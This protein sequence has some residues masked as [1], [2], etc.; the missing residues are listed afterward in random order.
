MADLLA[1]QSTMIGF[2]FIPTLVGSFY[3][4]NYY[5][6]KNKL[7]KHDWPAF[8]GALFFNWTFFAITY[9]IY[10]DKK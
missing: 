7:T 10:R 3:S 1:L 6:K 4:Y 8:W 5:K 9:F 2:M